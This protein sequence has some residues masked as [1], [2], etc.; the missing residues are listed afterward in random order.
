MAGLSGAVPVTWHFGSPQC[1]RHARI[2]SP[3]SVARMITALA[4]G[5]GAARLLE[6][7]V[8]VVPPDE[9][10]A[11]VNTGDDFVIHGLYVCPDLDTVTYTLAGVQNR[12]AGWGLADEHWMVME[13]LERY[14]APTWFRLG[15]RDLA[16]HLYRT[17]MLA[18][19]VPLSSVTASIARAWGLR[20]HLLPMSDDAVR[21]RI[22]LDESASSEEAGCDVA[23]QDYF[24]RLAHSVPVSGV[25]F[26]G[27]SQATP[28]P[29]VIESLETA[30]RIVICPSNPIVSIGPVLAVPGIQHILESRRDSVVAISPIIAGAALKGPADR[31]MA[32]LGHEA[33]AVGVA[34]IYA[35]LAATLYIDEADRDE[36][37]R[38]E[39][40]GMRCVVVPA[41]MS[42]PAHAARLAEA[43]LR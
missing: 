33:S 18:S 38:V 29:G 43:C 14:G 6:G 27:A 35:P 11:I 10:T 36:A 4:G 8:Q 42:T 34:R 28:A 25:R 31:M 17:G 20:S 3:G 19:G 40:A 16:T 1:R 7:L 9:V 2:R 39:A 15:D 12:A 32:Q 37:A 13:S 30:D 26:D 22:T 41:V 24:V 23:F 21:T 5:V